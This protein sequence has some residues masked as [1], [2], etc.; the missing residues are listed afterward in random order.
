MD[1]FWPTQSHLINFV[2]VVGSPV[3]NKSCLIFV[4]IKLQVKGLEIIIIM[5]ACGEFQEHERSKECQLRAWNS[6]LIEMVLKL[7]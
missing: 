3:K 4:N 6:S 2:S 7:S 1:I 5:D